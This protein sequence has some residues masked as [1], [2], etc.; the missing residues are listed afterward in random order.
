MGH[1][2]S[3]ML[4]PVLFGTLLFLPR[5]VTGQTLDDSFRSDI[6]KLLEV[7]GTSQ[8]GTQITQ[9]ISS[10]FVAGLKK[11]QPS[12]PDRALELAKQVLDAEMAK[13]FTGPDNLTQQ[14]VAIYAKYYT[15]EDVRGLLAFYSTD[16]GKKVIRLMPVVLQE[17]AAIGQQW[18]QKQMPGI[19]AALESRLRAE[20]FI[21]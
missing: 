8:M 20:G 9:L 17:A 14:I 19:A 13:A 18:A 4:L 5:P 21:K 11:S 6:E 15:H 12:I 16:L 1:Y 10:Q 3:R 7:T 2:F